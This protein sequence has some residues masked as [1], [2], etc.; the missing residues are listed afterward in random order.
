MGNEW[1][2]GMGVYDVDLHL[3]VLTPQVTSTASQISQLHPTQHITTTPTHTHTHTHTM[4]LA[5]NRTLDILSKAE[6]GKCE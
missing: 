5:G 6:K 1:D 3:L 2:N 4:S